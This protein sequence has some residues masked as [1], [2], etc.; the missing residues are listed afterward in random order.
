MRSAEQQ[1]TAGHKIVKCHIS[2]ITKCN[3][4]I[5]TGPLHIR[6]HD[7]HQFQCEW[8]KQNDQK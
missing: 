8:S 3:E 1:L 7:N 4:N 2:K 5:A 6:E